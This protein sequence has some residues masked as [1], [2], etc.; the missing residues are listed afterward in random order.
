MLEIQSLN[1]IGSNIAAAGAGVVARGG[2]DDDEEGDGD[3]VSTTI[4]TG[5]DGVVDVV[6]D[7]IKSIWCLIGNSDSSDNND[8]G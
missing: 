1:V 7:A 5:G 4:F 6:D 3:D 8:D 2:R